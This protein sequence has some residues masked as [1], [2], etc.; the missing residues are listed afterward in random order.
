[1]AP[2][3]A[4]GQIATYSQTAS[5]STI[6]A[7]HS[8]I[9]SVLERVRAFVQRANSDQDQ[10][11][12]RERL[13]LSGG[14]SELKL[15]R[16]FGEEDLSGAP[17]PTWRVWYE[18]SNL[19]A[20][21]AHVDIDL[22][23]SSRR[24]EVEGTSRE[25]VDALLALL[26]TDLNRLES[27]FGG[28]GHRSAGGLAL[29]LIGAVLAGL[30]STPVPFAGM[31]RWLVLVLGISLQVSVWVLPWETWF[32][33]TLVLP[34]NTSFL[35]RNSPLVSLVGLLATLAGIAVPVG[36]SILSARRAS[37]EGTPPR[38]PAA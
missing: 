1:M 18:Y 20:P 13:F 35:E 12:V 22:D 17:R 10:G 3:A 7:S 24:I 27:G 4:S 26:R 36:R 16:G 23:D 38:T 9:F 28:F 2:V 32:P 25:Q 29:L 31:L 11:Y 14:T 15:E 34:E 37:S 21:I 33:G 30:A 6:R 19:S 8:E 5:F